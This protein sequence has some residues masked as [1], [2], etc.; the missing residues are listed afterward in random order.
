MTPWLHRGLL[1]VAT[2]I[3]ATVVGC[4]HAEP[5]PAA[6][7]AESSAASGAVVAMSIVVTI[8]R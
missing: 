4:G 7:S 2:A 3:C 8:R 1:L 6:G 5:R